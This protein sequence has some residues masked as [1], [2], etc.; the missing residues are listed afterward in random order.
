MMDNL[1]P[2]LRLMGQQLSLPPTPSEK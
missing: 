1:K 2:L